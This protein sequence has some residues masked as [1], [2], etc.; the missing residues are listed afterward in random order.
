M[1]KRYTDTEKWKKKFIKTLPAEYKLFW[2]FLLDEC[3]HSGIWHIELDVAEA[4]LGIK[5]SLEKI[6][7]LF[8]ERVV[9]FDGGTKLFIPDFIE[10]QYGRLNP[11]NKV[12]KSV[13]DKLEKYGLMGRARGLQDPMDKDKD[14]EKDKEKEKEKEDWISE[15][16]Y[17][18]RERDRKRPLVECM[19]VFLLDENWVMANKTNRAE[20]EAFNEYLERTGEKEKTL[21]DYPK[22][23]AN[24]KFRSPEKLIKKT[25]SLDELRERAKKEGLV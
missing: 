15:K 9:E 11:S 8:S 5:L 19:N 2:L 7:G 18:E 4:R 1:P 24:L 6:R 3:D 16:D 21:L 13:L 25:L 23:F 20:L 12:H 10:F 14:K 17:W 22:H